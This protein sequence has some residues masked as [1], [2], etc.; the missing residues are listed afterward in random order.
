MSASFG[1]A[2]ILGSNYKAAGCDSVQQFV[3]ENF[4]S[5]KNQLRHMLNFCESNG[6]LGAL[7]RGDWVTFARSY[8]GPSYRANAYDNKLAAAAKR[9]R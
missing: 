2:Q 8:N 1:L 9:C 6:I 4:T 5:E 7:R 3:E